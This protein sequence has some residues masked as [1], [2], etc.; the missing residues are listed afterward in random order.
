MP[1]SAIDIFNGYV[2]DVKTGKRKACKWLRLAVKRHLSDL[3][4]AKKRGYVFRP[5]MLQ[6]I[7]DFCL[8]C[9]HGKG[10]WAGQS[11]I[12]QPWQVF[13]LGSI[14]CWVSIKTGMRRFRRVYAELPRK[15]GKSFIGSVIAIITYV[16]DGEGGPEVYTAATKRDQSRIVF[17]SAKGII[18]KSPDL[19]G[20]ITVNKYNITLPHDDAARFEPLSSDADSMDGLNTHCAIIDELH[21]HKSRDL[22]DVIESST[23]AREQSLIFAITTAGHN[24]NGICME[25]RRHCENVLSEKSAVDDDRLFIFISS[26]DDGDDWRKPS[27]W[28]KANPNYGISVLPDDIADQCK[29]AQAVPGSENEFRCKRLN[30]WV[31]QAER[32]IPI[33]KWEACK[34]LVEIEKLRGQPCYAGLDLGSTMDMSA[35]VLYFHEAKTLLPFFFCPEEAGLNNDKINRMA[36]DGWARDGFLELTP[37]NVVD[38]DWII[39]KAVELQGLFDIRE[40]AYDRWNATQ[41]VIKLQDEHGFKMVEFGMGYSSMASPTRE[42]ERLILSRELNHGQHPVLWWNANNIAIDTDPA[43]NMKPSKKKSTQKIDGLVAAIMAIG[44][45]MAAAGADINAI[46]RHGIREL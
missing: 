5:E 39:K 18:K 21:A 1:E 7:Y 41:T 15:N 45:S 23:G 35:L 30:Q 19:R 11:F 43:G 44:R 28:E 10:K 29:K 34:G 22:W 38:Y 32:W 9:K 13:L 46:A 42:L 36:Y 8:L 37:G 40:I 2:R 6:P 3:K 14:F 27:S 17:D 24:H 31:S 4:H 12:P 25:I 26:I 33:D 20:I 16:I